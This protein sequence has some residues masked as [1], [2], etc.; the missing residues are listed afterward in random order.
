LPSRQESTVEALIRQ[1][2]QNIPTF[3]TILK[4]NFIV[5]ENFIRIPSKFNNQK[6]EF[7]LLEGLNMEIG[8]EKHIQYRKEHEKKGGLYPPTLPETISL[9]Q[10]VSKTK[11]KI[12]RDFIHS[13]ILETNML[14]TLTNIFVDLGSFNTKIIHFGKEVR[15]RVFSSCING[16][17]EKKDFFEFLTGYTK[18]QVLSIS[19]NATGMPLYKE[20]E[21]FTKNISLL[22]ILKYKELGNYGIGGKKYCSF[23]FFQEEWKLP[24]SSFL[25]RCIPR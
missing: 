21:I 10:G 1:Q 11:N 15:E 13:S 19:K 6:V 24:I 22:A 8:V 2:W 16:H 5:M 23:G 14:L 7:H 20:F 18:K 3:F 12:A 17:S 25:I 4:F 9:M